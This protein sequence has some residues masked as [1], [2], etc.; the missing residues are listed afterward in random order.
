MK[1]LKIIASGP[2]E[3]RLSEGIMGYYYYE[4]S[5]SK[6][7][8]EDECVSS[9]WLIFSDGTFS[10]TGAYHSTI[11]RNEHWGEEG[12]YEMSMYNDIVEQMKAFKTDWMKEMHNDEEKSWDIVG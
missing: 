8:E 6:S 7:G 5:R 12:T 10:L 9:E 11:E 4:E 1:K 2:I 3:Y